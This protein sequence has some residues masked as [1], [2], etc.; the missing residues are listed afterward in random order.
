MRNNN[1]QIQQLNQKLLSYKTLKKSDT[2]VA[3]WLRV[4]RTTLGM[5][6]EQLGKKL[7]I[8]KQAILDAEKREQEGS[9]SIKTLRE[10]GEA[11]DMDLVYGFVPKDDS[12][13]QLIDRKA[14]ELAAQIVNRTSKSMKLEDQEN[15]AMRIRKAIEERAELIKKEKPKLLWD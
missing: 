2:P 15:S 4:I 11:L 13:D 6:M 9:I 3:G 8:S 14:R 10:I 5:S 12:L 7:S 1:L